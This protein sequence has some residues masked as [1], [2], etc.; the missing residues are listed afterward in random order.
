[1]MIRTKGDAPLYQVS[2]PVME[3]DDVGLLID[4]M[5]KTMVEHRSVGLAANQVG[6]TKRVI[7]V[8]VGG[9]KLSLIN[10]VITKRYGGKSGQVEECLSFPGGE[11]MMIR[12]NKIIVEG[13][14]RNRKPVR[15]KLKGLAAR[16]VQH[17]VDHLNGV[18]IL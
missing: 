8:L 17:E 6:V 3:D 18:T 7:V 12:H 16:C 9:L 1:M 2:Q 13:L 4:E 11:A 10:P 5:F 15:R 14:D